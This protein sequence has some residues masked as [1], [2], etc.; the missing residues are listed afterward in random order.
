MEKIMEDIPFKGMSVLIT[1]TLEG[2]EYDDNV[3]VVYVPGFTKSIV[4]SVESSI[5]SAMYSAHDSKYRY[6]KPEL[7]PGSNSMLSCDE[8]VYASKHRASMLFPTDQ[9]GYGI[10][11]SHSLE[12]VIWLSK[13]LEVMEGVRK[14]LLNKEKKPIKNHALF[15]SK[16]KMTILEALQRSSHLHVVNHDGV[17]TMCVQYLFGS[18]FPQYTLDVEINQD[19][20]TLE[21]KLIT[22]IKVG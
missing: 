14:L 11:P 10:C 19:R 4:F 13:S 22:G 8:W 12:T 7:K 15:T 18:K 1:D 9:G 5:R 6:V 2:L 16:L 21:T 3:H 20:D 17:N